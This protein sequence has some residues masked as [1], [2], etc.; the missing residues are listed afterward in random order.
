MFEQ[1]RWL[2]VENV[3][4]LRCGAGRQAGK[5]ATSHFFQKDL[6]GLKWLYFL[7]CQ[8][9]GLK[10]TAKL[11]DICFRFTVPQLQTISI[12]KSPSVLHFFTHCCLPLKTLCQ[13]CF[14]PIPHHDK[15]RPPQQ[16]CLT[17]LTQ[18]P[19]SCM[20]CPV[21]SLPSSAQISV[22]CL[23][24]LDYH[25]SSLCIHRRNKYGFKASQ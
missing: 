12:W 6:Y 24:E 25:Q 21:R 15:R 23:L 3:W 22:H 8:Y 9:V 13:T 10:L 7:M 2:R 1:R 14:L 4:L 11:G 16:S 20:Y 17:H 18:L 5:E 19:T